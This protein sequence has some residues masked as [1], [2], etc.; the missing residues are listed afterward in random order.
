[1]SSTDVQ[2]CVTKQESLGAA[3]EEDAAS[4]A[5]F[6]P[7]YCF[8]MPRTL[9]SFGC[10]VV[11]L[12]QVCSSKA[13]KTNGTR[14]T[15]SSF[16]RI[17]CCILIMS[18]LAA[19]IHHIYPGYNKLERIECE[20][21]NHVEGDLVVSVL[22]ERDATSLTSIP[23]SLELESDLRQDLIFSLMASPSTVESEDL[24]AECRHSSFRAATALEESR[25]E[26]MSAARP[27]LFCAGGDEHDNGSDGVQSHSDTGIANFLHRL[28]K[29]VNRN[30][31]WRQLPLKDTLYGF[32]AVVVFTVV[33]YSMAERSV[34]GAVSGG[35][36][37]TCE[38]D[39]RDGSLEGVFGR[40][41]QTARYDMDSF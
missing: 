14:R 34:V 8:G 35:D 13:V 40:V 11:R 15:C 24:A 28:S 2:A 32:V 27:G 18:I 30:A 22:Q 9:N 10:N 38:L 19:L 7:N 36:S 17:G 37:E 41:I 21:A 23:S 33:I 5:A 3:G 1:M 20:R 4:S 12:S 31:A 6:G 26:K 39:I 16:F 25:K 29:I